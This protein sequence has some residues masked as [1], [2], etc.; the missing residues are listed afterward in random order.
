[1]NISPI[2][3]N[4]H[5]TGGGGRVRRSAERAASTS[6]QAGNLYHGNGTVFRLTVGGS[7]T[8]VHS[9]PRGQHSEPLAAKVKA[10]PL[11]GVAL[12]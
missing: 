4:F 8:I 6:Q 10:R 2:M 9:F 3:A 7:V 5:A 11:C 12:C 1:M